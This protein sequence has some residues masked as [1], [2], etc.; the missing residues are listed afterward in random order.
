MAIREGFLQRMELSILLQPFDSRDF[1]TVSLRSK[2]RARFH[3]A[4]IQKHRAGTAISRIAPD[5]R[6]GQ[7]QR[8]AQKLHQQ[9]PR[10]HFPPERLSVHFHRDGHAHTRFRHRCGS[11]PC[12]RLVRGAARLRSI[13]SP[14]PLRAAAYTPP[15]PACPLAAPPRCGSLPPRGPSPLRPAPFRATPL[16]PLWPEWPSTPRNPAQSRRPCTLLLL[17]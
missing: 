11:P 17:S 12:V 14:V 13:A 7:L 1:A 16:L 10:F 9:R 15:C 6:P 8:F 4:A 3:R 2:R 5:V